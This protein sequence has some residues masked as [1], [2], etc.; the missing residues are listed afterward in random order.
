VTPAGSNGVF[1]SWQLLKG[2]AGTLFWKVL[3]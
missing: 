3:R 2:T 1:F